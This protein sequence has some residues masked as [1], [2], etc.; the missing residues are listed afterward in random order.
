MPRNIAFFAK[1]FGLTLRFCSGTLQNRKVDIFRVIFSAKLRIC[2]GN[3]FRF[4]P[5]GLSMF[6]MIW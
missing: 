5:Q 3:L 2:S 1:L 4:C 6:G